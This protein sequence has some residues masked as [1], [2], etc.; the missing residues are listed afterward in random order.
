MKID[1]LI[2]KLEQ[3]KEEHG[4]LKVDFMGAAYERKTVGDVIIKH[5]RI[6]NRRERKPDFWESFYG[7]TRKGEKVCKII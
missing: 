7:E 1:D 5:R 2:L 4:N 3:I 6:L